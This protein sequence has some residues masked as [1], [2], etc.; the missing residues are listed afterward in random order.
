MIK[1]WEWFMNQVWLITSLCLSPLA[2]MGMIC[3]RQ[4][5]DMAALFGGALGLGLM[6]LITVIDDRVR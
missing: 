1:A 5:M 6:T 2:I 3:S 4:D